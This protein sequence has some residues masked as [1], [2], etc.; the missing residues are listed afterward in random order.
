MTPPGKPSRRYDRIFISP[1]PDDVAFSCYGSITNPLATG[2]RALMVT[3]FGRSVFLEVKDPNMKMEDEDVKHVSRI[4][5]LE[6]EAFARYVNCDIETLVLPDTSIRYPNRLGQRTD[7]LPTQDPIYQDVLNDLRPILENFINQ[8][9]HIY[10]PL[11]IGE[12]LDHLIVRCAVQEL[13]NSSQILTANCA[14][15]RFYEDIP[16]ATRFTEIEK[17]HYAR[18]NVH[19]SAI[20]SKVDLDQRWSRK[21]K[22]MQLYKSQL[23]SSILEAADGH[24]KSLASSKGRAERN[25]YCPPANER[26]EHLVDTV[27]WV[28]WEACRLLGGCGVVMSGIINAQAYQS[29]VSRT[30]LIG[31][32]FVPIDWSNFNPLENLDRIA[33]A[34]SSTILYQSHRD[35][36]HASV[37]ATTRAAFRLIEAKHSVELVY[38]RENRSDDHV[39][40]RLLFDLSSLARI[41]GIVSPS[42]RLFLDDL[43][44]CFGLK[45]SLGSIREPSVAENLHLKSRSLKEGNAFSN[46]EY[47]IKMKAIVDANLDAYEDFEIDNIYGA[48]LGQPANE[49]LRAVIGKNETCLLIAQGSIALPSAYAVLMSI[50]EWETSPLKTLFYAGE[51]ATLSN[52]LVGLTQISSLRPGEACDTFNWDAPFR[53]LIMYAKQAQAAGQRPCHFAD[54][55]A[56]RHVLN[57]NTF[58]VLRQGNKLHGMLAVSSNVFDELCFLDERYLSFNKHSEPLF[59]HGVQKITCSLK[60]KISARRGLLSYAKRAWKWPVDP[61]DH[62]NFIV[63]TRISRPVIY[64]GL[65]RDIDIAEKM[66]AL[67]PTKTFIYLLITHGQGPGNDALKP[68]V[69]RASNIGKTLPNLQVR[70]INGFAWPEEPESGFPSTSLTRDEL[71]RATDVNFCLSMYDSYSI[72]ALESVSCGAICVISSSAGVAKR[73]QSLAGYEHNI[74]IIDYIYDLFQSIMNASN[75]HSQRSDLFFQVSHDER[76]RTEDAVANQAAKLIVEKLPNSKENKN[77]LIVTGSNLADQMSWDSE[78]TGGLLPEIRKLFNSNV[79]EALSVAHL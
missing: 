77:S 35:G 9:V 21:L 61:K 56:F 34:T 66:S 43:K 23:V 22:G 29:A 58:N 50:T 28:S 25:W 79:R 48:L 1:H 75:E 55:Q 71:H 31:P 20:S 2:S 37:S 59:H 52:F 78:V 19:L 16:Q 62:Q 54:F 42:L 5:L 15:L 10:V 8:G 72:A 17:L 73:V 76:Q 47:K 36:S 65:M 45:L 30:I 32:L 14:E 49:G 13:C 74:V 70:I 33:D 4:R 67:L 46:Q 63:L 51:V 41:G 69:A 18:H 38:M 12:H 57:E 3:V 44:Q 68:L 26:R 6:D 39:V 24:A 53:G 7:V 27:C 60:E 40:E 64:K 11:G